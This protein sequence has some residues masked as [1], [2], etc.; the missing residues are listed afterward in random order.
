MRRTFLR[1]AAVAATLVL[2]AT[3]AQTAQAQS[4]LNIVGTVNLYQLVSGFSGNLI[5]DFV[6]PVGPPN[7]IVSVVSPT[8]G[9]TGVFTALPPGTTGSNIDFVF[10]PSATPA[11]T[12]TPVAFLTIG[13]YTF[14]ATSF[15]PGNVPNTPITV[16]QVGTTGFAVL[17]V[18]GFVNGPG[19]L[20]N[21]AF[22]G[23]YTTQFPG[24]NITDIINTIQNN[25]GPTG[26]VGNVSIS[27][28]FVTAVPEPATVALMGTG[29]VA[30]FGAVRRRRNEA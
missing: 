18:N 27:A 13:G 6:P 2:S 1:G 23:A 20:P 3:V 25:P 12:T 19:L 21:T 4:K 30:L 28:T 14:T 17:A 11:P 5:V 26:G 16:G 24:Q 7:G 9:N 15:G 29:L 8:S 22:T 10:G